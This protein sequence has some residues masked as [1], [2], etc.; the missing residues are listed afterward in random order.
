MNPEKIIYVIEIENFINKIELSKKRRAKYQINKKG[1]KVISNPR[2]AN[3]PVYYKINGQDLWSGIPF[4]KRSKIAKELKSY[5]YEYFKKLK[6]LE[7]ENYPIG[8]TLDFYMDVNGFD[9][10]NFVIWYRK[11]IHDALCGKVEYIKI[12]DEKNKV[13]YVPNFEKY[14]P[15]IID[16]TVDYI[17]SMPTNYI[18][19]L[20]NNKLIIT[21]YKN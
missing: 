1:E 14:K 17:N 3:K 12:T 13:K 18:K 11:C 6:P 16:D 10:D 21:I 20:E 4:H 8:V 5:F 15:I 7:I 19:S 9:L 2:T